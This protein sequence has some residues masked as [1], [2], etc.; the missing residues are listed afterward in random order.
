MATT[1]T[2]SK[3]D[4]VGIESIAFMR[5]IVVTMTIRNAR[6]NSVMN[7][8]IDKEQVNNLCSPYGTTS[9]TPIPEFPGFGYYT[10]PCVTNSNGSVDIQLHIPGGRYSTGKKVFTVT[11][12]ATFAQL[13]INGST[14]G[15][16]TATF[17]SLGVI[18]TY[19]TTVTDTVTEV[20]F[21]PTRDPLAQSFFTYG[22][23]GGIFL[24]S[25][26]LYFETKDDTIP[27]RVE[28]REMINGYPA[29]LNTS[30]ANMVATMPPSGVL[31][32]EDA[33][34]ATNFKFRRPIYLKENHDYAFVIFSTSNKYNVFTSMLGEKSFETGRAIVNQ[35]YV[36]SMFKSENNITWT[37]EQFQDIKFNLKIAE[38]NTS[39][40]AIAKFT[41]D[42]PQLAVSGEKFITTS[43]SSLISYTQGFQHGLQ[44][45]DKFSVSADTGGVYNGIPAINLDNTF[46]VISV[47]NEYSIIFD[48]GYVATSTGPITSA[49]YVRTIIITNGGSGYSSTTP[50]TVNIASGGGSGAT[51]TAT[52]V[53]GVVTNILITNAGTGYTSN[54]T[55]SI[56]S[57][58]GGTGATAIAVTDA[59]F[60]IATNKL[61]ND[62]VA[63][64]NTYA[65]ADT[66]VEGTLKTTIGNY[67]GGNL[68][69]Y[70]SGKE[71]PF[72]PNKRIS[73]DDS[74]V[75]ASRFNEVANMSANSS[76]NFNL[77][78]RSTNKNISP[79]IDLRDKPIIYA[80]GNSIRNQSGEDLTSTN[81][82]G[83]VSS[84]VMSSAG[85]GYTLPPI[86][87]FVGGGGTGA[88]G[89]A[90]LSGS[91]VA[92]VTITNVGSGFTSTPTVVFTRA[93]GDT[94]GSGATGQVV[95]T[96]FNTEVYSG[97]GTALTRY[98]TKPIVLET[99]SSGITIYSNIYSEA[100]SNVDWY[101]RTSLSGSG[102]DHSTVNW[103]ILSCDVDRNLSSK[104]G[105]FLEYE[106]RK[107]GIAA[108]DTYDLK[109]VMRSNTP[110][111]APS[112]S[113]YR[114]VIVA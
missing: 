75:I 56:V 88:A 12:A 94:T 109:C 42:V 4:L 68:T 61:V 96:P 30:D 82:F 101:I 81:P 38:F 28:L 32:S 17:D 24:T 43:G 98:I 39:A 104:V 23:T 14:F 100:Q 37:A 1:T 105:E 110:V 80:Y 48:C 10:A 15:R 29:P 19:Q 79:V 46:N 102:V 85:S 16:A 93:S 25:I 47:I 77:I 95:L 58:V 59:M 36:G 7:I 44:A 70:T 41:V 78:L 87:S 107:F 50:P 27:V 92:S 13:E 66:A 3:T 21:V 112:M 62:I 60:T 97:H 5:P 34:L 63:K 11:D 65:V 106:F 84:I 18:N 49:R 114:V 86:V 91:T 89:T 69:T 53:G 113:D 8:F 74:T 45:G 57:S 2:V 55:V 83:T 22:A 35:P 6:P 26:D 108:F 67:A 76:L 99:V 64:I 51:A 103:Q 52:V 111:K 33:S 54:P 71:Y 20:V 40:N 31:V 72:I 90:V 73:F 9:G